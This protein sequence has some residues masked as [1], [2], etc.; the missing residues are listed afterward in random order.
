GTDFKV[1]VTAYDRTEVPGPHESATGPHAGASPSEFPIRMAGAFTLDGAADIRVRGGYAFVTNTLAGLHIYRTADLLDG[2]ATTTPSH[3]ARLAGRT[4][5]GVEIFGNALYLYDPGQHGVDVIDVGDPEAPVFVRNVDATHCYQHLVAG[6]RK[7]TD[8]IGTFAYGVSRSGAACDGADVSF[9]SFDVRDPSLPLFRG[10]LPLFTALGVAATEMT[11]VDNK[12]IIAFSGIDA[13]NEFRRLSYI[14]NELLTVDVTSVGTGAMEILDGVPPGELNWSVGMTEGVT[15]MTISGNENSVLLYASVGFTAIE[16]LNNPPSGELNVEEIID[17]RGYP[18]SIK[19][20][21]PYLMVAMRT[22]DNLVNVYDATE[23]AAPRLIGGLRTTGSSFERRDI[24]WDFDGNH[25]FMVVNS[26]PSGP[27]SQEAAVVVGELA[28]PRTLEPVM[29]ALGIDI[30][31][32]ASHHNWAFG[33]AGEDESLHLY[34]LLEGMTP[35]PR[36]RTVSG[37]TKVCEG[38]AVLFDDDRYLA[39]AALTGVEPGD[40]YILIADVSLLCTYDVVPGLCQVES[41]AKITASNAVE[42][43]PSDVAVHGN[44]LYVSWRDA[45][46][47]GSSGEKYLACYNIADLTD[48]QPCGSYPS[49]SSTGSGTQFSIVGGKAY[50]GDRDSP[51]IMELNV[52]DHGGAISL[53]RE[54]VPSDIDALTAVRARGRDVLVLGSGTTDLQIWDRTTLSAPALATVDIVNLTGSELQYLH[55]Y[56]DLAVMSVSNPGNSQFKV[57]FYDVGDRT[58]PAFA[59]LL[60]ADAT[61]DAMLVGPFMLTNQPSLDLY[62]LK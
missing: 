62:L 34:N 14:G 7:A 36:T 61:R 43:L 1:L 10:T 51:R 18:G 28:Q 58:Q 8:D 12:V 23:A 38:T 46:G 2:D 11:I 37:L 20:Y 57:F 22:G 4:Q 29:S 54:V 60:M 13:G 25:V 56:T 27:A 15:G 53:S 24:A 44:N 40:P 47:T 52:D 6:H 35:E 50:V 55:V 49:G 17:I 48:I 33:F 32:K 59:N 3:V 39:L 41:L 5:R 21:G 19:W 16:F 42:G 45:G 31:V 30:Q 9:N 26:A